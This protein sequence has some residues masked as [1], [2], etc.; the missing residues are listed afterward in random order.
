MAGT[1]PTDAGVSTGGAPGACP[2]NASDIC[3]G[4]TCQPAPG[5]TPCCPGPGADVYCAARLGAGATCV[6]DECTACTPALAGEYTVDPVH[7]SDSMGTGNTQGGAQP[8]CALATVTRAL[9]IVGTAS[10]IQNTVTVIGGAAGTSAVVGPGE[11][12]PLV[13]PQNVA[14]TTAAGP[15]VVNVPAGS[16]GFQLGAGTGGA[17]TVAG[18]RGGTGSSLTIDGQGN[19]ASY[20]IVATT[21]STVATSIANLTVSRFLDDGILVENAGVLSIGAGVTSTANGTAAARKAGLHVTGSGHAIITASAGQAG[22]HF[23]GNTSHGIFVDASGFITL[24]GA[25][26][27]ATH[28]GGTV[29]ANDN[30]TA[31]LWIQQTPGMPP[32]NTVAG[33]VSFGSG[34]GNGLRIV[35]GSS[36]KLRGSVS[37][38]NHGSG[39][40]VSATNASS[41]ISNIDLGDE[42]GS[43]YGRNMF[44]Q[45]RSGGASNGAVGVC[46]MVHPNSGVL[47][48]AGNV[49][50]AGD[51]STTAATLS[52]NKTACANAACAG[53]VCDLGIVGAGNDVDVKMCTH[54]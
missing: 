32:Q 36:V 21:G 54:R 30:Y 4:L 39:V 38:G 18:I 28:G 48:A 3:C 5:S 24:T 1:C 7:G 34:T 22:T 23:D 27:N 33:L 35:A 6:D 10:S 31:G 49:F 25:V 45:P 51:C 20:G 8:G 47:R 17:G 53:G 29:T 37:L 44:Q 43:D 19:T 16:S 42:V 50:S 9:Q 13:V 2:V 52:A 14:I 12:F 46:L 11:T 41:D 26:T 40:L 15:V